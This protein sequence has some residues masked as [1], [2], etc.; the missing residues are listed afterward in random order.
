MDECWLLSFGTM[1][2]STIFT[3]TRPKVHLLGAL[4]ASLSAA[5]SLKDNWKWARGFSALSCR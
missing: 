5:P 1:R 4:S 2:R 3:G